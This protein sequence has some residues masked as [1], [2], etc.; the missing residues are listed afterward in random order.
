[1]ID[2]MTPY[3]VKFNLK[4]RKIK[5]ILIWRAFH[6]G[7]ESRER[8]IT[9]ATYRVFTYVTNLVLLCYVRSWFRPEVEEDHRP[10]IPNEVQVP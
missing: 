2:K 1:M 3:I 7:A 9:C 10:G 5:V 4:K 6:S 8:N